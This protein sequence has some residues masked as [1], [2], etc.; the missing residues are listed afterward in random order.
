[1]FVSF[2]IAMEN[3]LLVKPIDTLL[4]EDTTLLCPVLHCLTMTVLFPDVRVI[5]GLQVQQRTTSRC[6]D[7]LFDARD[8]WSILHKNQASVWFHMVLMFYFSMVWYGFNLHV[9]V[10]Y[11]FDIQFLFLT[12]SSSPERWSYEFFSGRSLC[13]IAGKKNVGKKSGIDDQQASLIRIMVILMVYWSNVTWLMI[14]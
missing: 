9:P 2:N 12:K 5:G 3:Y 13:D 6:L 7:R 10:S 14:Q 1:M 8:R 4:L 11:G